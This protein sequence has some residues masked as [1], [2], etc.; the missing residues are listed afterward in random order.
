MFYRHTQI[1]FYVILF[2]LLLLLPACCF[3]IISLFC[4]V[5][6]LDEKENDEKNSK[7]HFFTQSYKIR[8]NVMKRMRD[9][10]LQI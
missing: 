7:E 2:L 9:L 3:M 8:Q 5:L 4:P 1:Y 6:N 10:Y